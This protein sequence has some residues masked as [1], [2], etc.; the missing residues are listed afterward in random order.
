MR[1]KSC[2]SQ[3]S[4]AEGRDSPLRPHRTGRYDTTNA[5]DLGVRG[6]PPESRNIAVSLVAVPDPNPDPD[7]GAGQR[8]LAN[9]NRRVDI[10]EWERS[11]DRISDGAYRAG[12]LSQA[13]LERASRGVGSSTWQQG[14]RVDAELAKEISIIHAL[15][16]ARK[17]KAHL[18][19]L[20]STLG[21]LD[22]LIL[23]Q[24]LGENRTYG[25]VELPNIRRTGTYESYIARRFRDALE[26]LA[27]QDVARA[28][29]SAPMR[30]VTFEENILVTMVREAALP[31]G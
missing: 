6:V 20:G 25:K 9:V 27:E 15:E 13:I 17:V 12:R 26:A 11:H 18:Q 21:K 3:L 22:T 24:V 31:S 4:A 8:V 14:S 5:C 29:R 23:H 30:S 1:W 10:L 16:D 28:P 19:Y 2:S 7:R